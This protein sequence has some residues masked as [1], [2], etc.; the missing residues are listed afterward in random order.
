M[1]RYLSAAVLFLS[2]A[3]ALI[4]QLLWIKQ[5]S[6]VVGVDVYAVT[7]AVSAFFAGLALG[8]AI[9]GRHADRVARPL[10]LYAGIELGIGI[11]GVAATFTLAHSAPLFASIESYAG[12]AAWLLPFLL[13][14]LPAVL[15]GGTVPVMLRAVAADGEDVVGAGGALYAAN[16]TGAI[17]GA[18]AVP[19]ALIP[20]FG[21][22]GSALAAAGLNI[23]SA[24]VAAGLQARDSY[25]GLKPRLHDDERAALKGRRHSSRD[26]DGTIALR[27]YA[28]AGGIA[29]G[30]EVIW[31]QTIVQFIST[32]VFAF[33]IVL[34]TYLGGLATGSA[35]YAR[36][37]ARI[38]RP[39]LAFG[40]LVG[41]AALVA[42]GEM[43]VL[44]PW[45]L[46][47]ESDAEDA[48]RAMTGNELAAMC[49]RFIVAALG[50]VFVP[51]FLLG[52]AFPA[53]LEI[54]GSPDEPGR[55]SGA[56]LGW[57]TAG[58]IA[59]TLLTG[60]FLVPALGLVRTLGVLGAGGAIVGAVAVWKEREGR[61]RIAAVIIAAAAIAIAGLTPEDRLAQLLTASRSHGEVVFYAESAGGTVAVV[62]Q[63]AG[64]ATFRRLYIQG[65]SNSGDALTS[66]RY[67]RLQALLPLLIHRGEPK[68]ALVIGLGTGITSGALLTWPGL[69]HRVCA[70][71]LPAVVQAAPLFRGNYNA[72]SDSRLE[73]RVRDGRRELLGTEARYDLITLEPPPPS[74]QGVVNLYSRDFYELAKRRL[75]VNGILAQWWPL[76]TQNDEDSR[77]LVRSFLDA[78]PYASLWTTELHE[79]LL[80]GSNEAM[81]LDATRIASRFAQPDIATALSEVGVGTPAALMATWV[82]GRDRLESYAREAEPVTDDRPRIEY[83]TW[84]RRDEFTR[85]L[86]RVLALQSSPPLVNADGA[87]ERDVAIDL[88]ELRRFYEAGLRAAKGDRPAAAAILEQVMTR[89]ASN[90]YYRWMAGLPNN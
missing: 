85:V 11:A 62:Q 15:M 80:V 3:A 57:N 90:P 87:F 48:L 6:L 8:S 33:A 32:R 58:G 81:E 73:I 2:G 38:R 34:A 29:L 53:V 69:E 17:V 35:V 9:I 86:P 7:T 55:T 39:W 43:A 26:G 14:G 50:I 71:L 41:A 49:G 42:L 27:L 52:A 13:V 66:L 28:L 83:A 24:L 89:N 40:L 36:F 46:S 5:L 65:V 75:E 60:F 63:Q 51:T 47:L 61:G 21:V 10:Q 72:A 22:R 37:P 67:M 1:I 74:A 82:A 25:A 44:G 78:F 79:M 31:S 18:L 84:T 77:A 88:A 20:T 4:F 64:P 68:S 76:P 23:V 12:P 56:V 45:L 59:G 54:A 70:E 16:T 19:F 30:Y